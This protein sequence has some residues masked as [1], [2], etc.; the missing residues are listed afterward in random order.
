MGREC[1]NALARP[2]SCFSVESTLKLIWC[3][4][5]ATTHTVSV[6]PLVAAVAAATALNLHQ[7]GMF[8]SNAFYIE[9]DT[10]Y[11]FASVACCGYCKALLF[12]GFNR[13][14]HLHLLTNI[15]CKK[16]SKLDRSLSI[17]FDCWFVR[18]LGRFDDSLCVCARVFVCFWWNRCV[19]LSSSFERYIEGRCEY[20]YHTHNILFR[21][22][23]HVIC[24][25]A[26]VSHLTE[27]EY[28]SR[29]ALVSS[30]SPAPSTASHRT[31]QPNQAVFYQ[32]HTTGIKTWQ[33]QRQRQQTVISIAR[34]QVWSSM[35]SWPRYEQTNTITLFISHRVVFSSSFITAC[36]GASLFLARPS[37]RSV[38][39]S[40]VYNLNEF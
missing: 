33:Q 19:Q 20:K 26:P 13:M 39:Q 18:L 16:I 6:C 31:A 14:L 29:I 10:I 11:F 38:G 24:A 36:D 1:A 8:A 21:Y 12:F 30:P 4:E 40:I 9:Y 5:I 34:K 22:L 35:C 27:M 3:I 2:S 7:I 17:M 23:S 37:M 25:R 15:I 32:I 28:F